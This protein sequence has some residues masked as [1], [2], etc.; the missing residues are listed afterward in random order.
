MAETKERTFGMGSGQET[1]ETRRLGP[2]DV[3]VYQYKEPT[4]QEWVWTWRVHGRAGPKGT[5]RTMSEA[6]WD[7]CGS[8]YDE[9]VPLVK[10]ARK[11]KKVFDKRVEDEGK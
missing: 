4:T 3:T 7:L 10:F 9:L 1:P 5:F 11:L 8:L 2:F 6:K